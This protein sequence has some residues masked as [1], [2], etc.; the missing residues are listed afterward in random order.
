MLQTLDQSE[1]M[2]YLRYVIMYYSSLTR[3]WTNQS[4]CYILNMLLCT[5]ALLPDDDS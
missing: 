2:L 1:R 4:A 5:I 3:H